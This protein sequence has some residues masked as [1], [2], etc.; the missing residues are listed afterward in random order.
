[1]KFRTRNSDLFCENV[2]S[3]KSPARRR[4]RRGTRR[5]R[6][7]T[8]IVRQAFGYRVEGRARKAGKTLGLAQ[9]R[10]G[11]GERGSTRSQSRDLG[12]GTSVYRGREDFS[13][14]ANARQ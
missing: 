2:V 12:R 5:H 3:Q 10:G 9:A 13:R 1:M 14:R 6:G 8:P 4:R 11:G 7:P